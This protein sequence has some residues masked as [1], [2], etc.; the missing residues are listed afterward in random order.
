MRGYVRKRHKANCAHRHDETKKC[1]CKGSWQARYADPN[2][3][4]KRIEKTFGPG[5]AGQLAADD[6]LTKQR[7]SVLSGTHVDPR[8]A[9]RPFRD[10]IEEWRES[11]HRLS[12]TTKRRY[13]SVIDN[14]LIPEFGNV[15]I[16]RITHAVVQTY[17][18]RLVAREDI[19]AGTVRNVYAVLRTAMAKG[20]RMGLVRINP[21]TDV[22]LPR[23]SK[24]P[25]LFLTAAEV[26]A[27]AEAID[28]H[29]R[30]WVYVAAYSGLRAGELAG[31]QRQDV[32]LLRGVVHV[33]RA[34]KD[35]NGYLELGPTKTHAQRVV[36][37]PK[38]IADMLAEHLASSPGGPDA[39]VFTMK[40][41]GQLRHG[42]VYSNYFRRA[43]VGNP[44]KGIAP[45]LP[46][47]KHGLR[48]HDLR[49]TCAS[50]GVASGANVKQ[51]QEMLGHSSI[52]ITLDRYAHL[53]PSAHEDLAANLAATFVAAEGEQVAN[54]V[55][56]IGK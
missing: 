8:Q 37:L 34:L 39:P 23:A 42:L 51:V 7:S 48:F 43:V 12:P 24:E 11:W 20:V 35:V 41:G 32:D 18:D 45:A 13:E 31:L 3:F 52:T 50:L 1:N 36:S 47:D 6:W 2:N 40:G 17:V 4:G 55:V 54:N 26:R 38:P 10:V 21:C 28:P 27:V 5:R 14:Y 30:V 49:H 56:A 33:R 53:F 16:G 22:D 44:E 25:M 46:A 19:A 15:P 9:E 29:Y